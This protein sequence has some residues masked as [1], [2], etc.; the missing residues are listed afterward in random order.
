MSARAVIVEDE[1][2]GVTCRFQR[3]ET[4]PSGSS[5]TLITTCTGYPPV[6]I[7]DPY[8]ARDV[9]YQVALTV[10]GVDGPQVKR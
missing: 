5:W 9:L 3:D 4:D 7:A 2:A 6:R 10:L 8:D 1:R